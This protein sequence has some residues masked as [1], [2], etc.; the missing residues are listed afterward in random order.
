MQQVQAF[1]EA[2]A[3]SASQTYVPYEN[4]QPIDPSVDVRQLIEWIR[5]NL[6]STNWVDSLNALNAL[7]QLNKFSTQHMN[8]ICGLVW[9]SLLKCMASVKTVLAKTS[10]LFMQ[11]LFHHSGAALADPIILSFEPA[12]AQKCHC[13]L[14]ALK[15]EAQKAY[16]LLIEKV[17]KDATIIAVANTSQSKNPAVSEL[18]FKALERLVSL[19]GPNVV[20]LQPQT[21]K[22]LLLVVMQGLDG[23]RAEVHKS[24]ENIVKTLYQNLGDA[25]FSTLI[26]AMLTEAVLKPDDLNKLKKV[27]EVKEA[28]P[29]EPNLSDALKQARLQKQLANDPAYSAWV[30][31]QAMA[32]PGACQQIPQAYSQ[33]P[34]YQG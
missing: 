9:P 10:L 21:F 32:G 2:P 4:L 26:N 14:N 18:S 8:E 12:L 25:N 13:S 17:V 7:R 19:V 31:Q 28:K 23:K 15:V 34:T 24:S 20:Q 5:A 6:D 1:P 16:Q 22:E 30:A 29:K 27:F 11:E 33:A 3:E